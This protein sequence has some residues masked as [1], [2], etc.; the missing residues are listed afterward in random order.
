MQC[1]SCST[2]ISSGAPFCPN[3]GAKQTDTP[4]DTPTA[5]PQKLG[6]MDRS[7]KAIDQIVHKSRAVL[8]VDFFERN[9]SYAKTAALWSTPSAA[10]I[11][12]LIGIVAAIKNDSFLMALLG[13]LWVVTVAIAYY[14]GQRFLSVCENSLKANETT[15]SSSDYLDCCAIVGIAA[16]FSIAFWGLY[17][18]IRL[19]DFS[20]LVITAV[21]IVALTYYICL[22]L[23]PQLIST[24]IAADTSAGEDALSIVMIMYKAGVKLATIMFGGLSTIGTLFLLYVLYLAISNTRNSFIFYDL[25]SVGGVSL[26]LFGLLYPLGIYLTFIFVYLIVDLCKAILSLRKK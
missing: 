13:M 3:C 2:E 10:I 4:T 21:M 22:L 6:V 17:S 1:A 11:G 8:S 20:L 9:N 7:N 25:N 14:I 5:T 23:N 18:S 12:L 24:R 19:S 15:I 26:V 16:L